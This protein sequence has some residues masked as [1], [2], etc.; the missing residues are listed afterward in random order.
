MC[1]FGRRA[2]VKREKVERGLN[3][4]YSGCASSAGS[5]SVGDMDV[6]QV[7]ILVILDVPLR[8]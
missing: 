7:L 3:P 5:K 6:L 8:R 2:K 4:C 1:L